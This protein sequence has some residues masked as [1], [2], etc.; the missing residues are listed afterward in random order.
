MQKASFPPLFALTI[1]MSSLTAPVVCVRRF[2]PRHRHG[3]EL[4]GSGMKKLRQ[5]TSLLRTRISLLT[6][7]HGRRCS[8]L[9][10][11]SPSVR[12]AE[13]TSRCF[14]HC[15]RNRREI[16]DKIEPKDVA[17]SLHAGSTTQY[18]QIRTKDNSFLQQEEYAADEICTSK[19]I[20]FSTIGSQ[21]DPARVLPRISAGLR[22]PSSDFFVSRVPISS[23]LERVRS[24][25][26]RKLR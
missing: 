16:L 12:K 23:V 11:G 2:E 5:P 15:H 24:K 9:T 21:G 4:R 1:S 19:G 10:R 17:P 3:Q 7:A 26:H 20:S 13:L 18:S 22:P 25:R 14:Q 8:R 6:N